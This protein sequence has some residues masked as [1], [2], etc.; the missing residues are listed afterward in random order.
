MAFDLALAA[1]RLRVAKCVDRHIV[2]AE[3]RI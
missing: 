2:D 1:D 3:R